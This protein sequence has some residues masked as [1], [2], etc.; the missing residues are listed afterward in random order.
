MYDNSNFDSNKSRRELNYDVMSVMM[1]DVIVEVTMIEIKRKINFLMKL[2]EER[3]HEITCLEGLD[4][5][6]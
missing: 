2:F 5:G 6:S 4:V 3:D 1:A